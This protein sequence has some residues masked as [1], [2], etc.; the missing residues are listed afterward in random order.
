MSVDATKMP[1]PPAAATGS[2]PLTRAMVEG[3]ILL[4]LVRLTAPN[5]IWIVAQ[6]TVSIGE[7]YFVGW[8]GR[9]AL[10]GVSL[11]FPLVMLMQTMAGGG[12]GSGTA[13]AIARALGGRRH[14]DADALVMNSLVI[15][16]C[17]GL[18]FTI[19]VLLGGPALFELMGGT[20]TALSIAETYA[21]VTFSG[22]LLFWLFNAL[23]A[24]L[25]GAGVMT[26]PAWVSVIGAVMTLT[27]S[28]ALIFGIGPIP[29]YGVAGAAFAMLAYYVVGVVVL[30]AFL[31]AGRAPP[32]L[33]LRTRLEWRLCQDVLRVGSCEYGRIQFRHSGLHRAGWPIRYRR[34]SRLRHGGAP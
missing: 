9:D 1:Q 12:I 20:G 10:A 24:I 13:S 15:A 5:I 17:F 19:S 26:L 3:P 32:R 22:V 27:V 6:A 2:S 29:G 25:R 8:L 31:I 23:G 33:V 14:K 7:T 21:K 28:P 34:D 16:A 11:V 30:G 4:T 18:A